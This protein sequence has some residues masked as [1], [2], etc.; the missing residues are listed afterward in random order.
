MVTNKNRGAYLGT[1]INEKWW[2]RYRKDKFFARGSGYYWYDN[3]G[4]YFLRFLTKEPIFIP[5]NSV[6]EIK[7]GKWHAGKWALG[8]FFVKVIWKKDDLK[9]SS[10]FAVSGLPISENKRKAVMLKE[11]LEKKVKSSGI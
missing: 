5:F 9:L 2:T 4:L 6:I 7:L 11:D 8:S 3:K 10:G 1:E